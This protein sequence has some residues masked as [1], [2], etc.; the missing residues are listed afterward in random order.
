MYHLNSE[1]LQVTLADPAELRQL[2]TRFDHTGFI[3]EVV[4]DK[5]VRFCASEPRNMKS[6]SSGGRGLCSEFCFDPSA[7]AGIGEY[8]PKFGVGL[9]KKTKNERFCFY[10]KY[11]YIPFEH[12]VEQRGKSEIVF[13][14]LPLPCMGYA[15]ESTRI[16]TVEGNRV[17]MK[18]W[19]S[20][21]GERPFTVCEYCHNFISLDGMALGPEYS[22][23]LPE[24]MNIT[25]RVLARK[26]AEEL[27]D[28]AGSIVRPRYTSFTPASFRLEAGDI[29]S[30]VPFIW[31]LHH[32]GAN[33]TVEGADFFTP[34][35]VNIWANDHMFCP[36]VFVQRSLL[37]GQSCE[38][39][40]QWLFHQVPRCVK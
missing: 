3:T 12:T 29:R 40:R 11:E 19:L 10:R 38:W 35:E 8:F 15:V 37:H 23:T 7:E 16:V 26:E 36:E 18:I 21:V 25:R 32:D 20:N 33:V 31:Y 1:R 9:L 22:L 2:T 39:K 30:D 27:F 17:T 24:G 14:T 6:P 34:F 13:R 4:L 5:T 28:V